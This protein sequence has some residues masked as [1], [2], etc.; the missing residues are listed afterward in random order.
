MERLATSVKNSTS[1]F[2]TKHYVRV[3]NFFKV[4][5]VSSLLLLLIS[6]IGFS[7]NLHHL[8][9]DCPPPHRSK[10]QISYVVGDEQATLNSL[11]REY[12]SLHSADL[13]KV[14]DVVVLLK[15]FEAGITGLAPNLAREMVI[16]TQLFKKLLNL[17]FL[18]SFISNVQNATRQSIYPRR[19]NAVYRPYRLASA[20]TPP[21]S[22]PSSMLEISRT[23]I[24]ITD[25]VLL[26]GEFF[27][28]YALP[29][30]FTIEELHSNHKRRA[31]LFLA[32]MRVRRL[33]LDVHTVMLMNY[34]NPEQCVVVP[35]EWNRFRMVGEHQRNPCVFVFNGTRTFVSGR[36]R[37]LSLYGHS[38]MHEQPLLIRQRARTPFQ[39][40][41]ID[42]SKLGD[43]DAVQ[44][45]IFTLPKSTLEFV[46]NA[47]E[48]FCYDLVYRYSADVLASMKSW[49]AR[50]IRNVK[51]NLDEP[52]NGTIREATRKIFQ[53][54]HTPHPLNTAVRSCIALRTRFEAYIASSS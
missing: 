11:L 31:A 7:V 46:Y 6:I 10:R 26:L 53:F 24:A 36:R 22:S 14:D 1:A 28:K 8:L 19:L 15:K 16:Q 18:V 45:R 47:Y 27:N 9:D 25:D 33:P 50:Y 34:L 4:V 23:L 37:F 30:Y 49:L 20:A 3:V 5:L 13:N 44:T 12:R 29:V 2:Y 43:F 41:Y 51:L 35:V 54:V 48:A 21:P 38:S 42:F 52:H 17:Q 39:F 32:I 40:H